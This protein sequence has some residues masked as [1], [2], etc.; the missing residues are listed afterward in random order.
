MTMKH[1]RIYVATQISYS[2]KIFKVHLSTRLT[3]LL[4]KVNGPTVATLTHY[5]TSHKVPQTVRLQGPALVEATRSS[6]VVTLVPYSRVQITLPTVTEVY[7]M[8]HL[9]YQCRCTKVQSL[10]NGS[11]W[12]ST[13]GLYTGICFLTL[14]WGSWVCSLEQGY[15]KLLVHFHLQT[16][17]SLSFQCRPPSLQ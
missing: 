8:V 7:T 1:T 4:L 16:L 2:T 9:E 6:L 14:H 10:H 12:C 15:S 17:G 5:T 11:L 13:V 3:W